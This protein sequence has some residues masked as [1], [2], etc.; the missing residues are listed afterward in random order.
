MTYVRVITAMALAAALKAV[1]LLFLSPATLHHDVHGV[2]SYVEV[3]GGLYS[4]IVAFLIY[5]VW[6]Q[7]NRVQMG[8]SQ[9]AS[10]LE[11]LNRVAAF[12]SDSGVAGT[13][14]GAIKRYMESTG[15]DEPRRLA[16]GQLSSLAEEHFKALTHSIRAVEVKTTKDGAI[17]QEMLRGLTRVSDTRDERLGVSAT[18]IPSTLWYLVVFASFA[19]FAGFLVLGITSVPL[20]MA[21]V[22]AVAG[23]L[24]FLLCVLQDMDN[25][26]EGSWRA[27]YAP[28]VNIAA[29]ISQT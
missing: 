15:G 9:E 24:M 23:C 17:Y 6:D 14:R 16:K 21:I 20:S 8:V 13:I 10:A 11:D 27:S 3:L 22:A 26:F 5:V 19:L 12:L 29:R 25:P 1:T 18:R 7:F 28:M 2:G 4:I